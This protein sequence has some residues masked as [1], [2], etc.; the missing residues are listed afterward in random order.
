MN[1]VE[2]IF[3]NN[4]MKKFKVYADFGTLIKQN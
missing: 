3:I 2:Y 4:E 1:N